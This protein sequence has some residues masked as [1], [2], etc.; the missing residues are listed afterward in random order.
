MNLT[1][2]NTGI[3]KNKKGVRLGRGKGSGTG[4]TAGRGHKG[5]GSRNGSS[6]KVGFEGG[7]M[8]LFVVSRSAVSIMLVPRKWQTSTFATSIN[9]SRTAKWFLRKP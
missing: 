8:P 9:S 3:H 4:K 1:F 7:Q 2:V 6:Q 5:F